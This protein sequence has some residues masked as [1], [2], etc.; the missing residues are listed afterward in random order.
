MG[1]FH[2]KNG[3]TRYDDYTILQEIF[4]SVFR[5]EVGG[6]SDDIIQAIHSARVVGLL[7]S[8]GFTSRLANMSQP[9]PIQDNESGA[10]NMLHLDGLLINPATK[11]VHLA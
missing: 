5:R 3:W 2:M 9:E 10:Y 8:K 7:L 6:L 1:K 11:F 4:W